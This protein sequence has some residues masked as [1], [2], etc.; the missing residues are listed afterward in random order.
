MKEDTFGYGLS[1]LAHSVDKYDCASA[2]QFATSKWMSIVLR[3]E[4]K[5]SSFIL[6]TW[7][8]LL[9]AAYLLNDS[10]AFKKITERLLLSYKDSYPGLRGRCDPTEVIPQK[11]YGQ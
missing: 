10:L 6:D 11:V 9:P 5:S 7:G 4:D 3:Y 2:T 8:R 1:N